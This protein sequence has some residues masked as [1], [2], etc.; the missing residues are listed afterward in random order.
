MLIQDPSEAFG[1]RSVDSGARPPG[2]FGAKPWLS[3]ALVRSWQAIVEVMFI[4]SLG[5][6]MEDSFGIGVLLGTLLE[7]GARILE[8]AGERRRIC[9]GGLPDFGSL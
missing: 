9:S 6:I 1:P 8:A 4:F 3:K 2:G 7:I 5:V